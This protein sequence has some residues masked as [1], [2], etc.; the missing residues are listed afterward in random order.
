[1]AIRPT[2]DSGLWEARFCHRQVATIDVRDP[3]EV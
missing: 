1:V 2:D 3:L